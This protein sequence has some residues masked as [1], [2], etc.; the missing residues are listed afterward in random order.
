MLKKLEGNM[1]KVNDIWFN[2]N[3][4]KFKVVSVEDG[5]VTY[6]V[7]YNDFKLGDEYSCNT[8]AFVDRFSKLSIK[9]YRS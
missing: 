4:K 8:E 3:L 7:F 5:K 2:S 9:K 6:K 1:P